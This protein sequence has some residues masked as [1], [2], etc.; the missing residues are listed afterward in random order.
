[1][2]KQNNKCPKCGKNTFFETTR[3]KKDGSE[4]SYNRCQSCMYH[5]YDMTKG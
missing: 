1:M 3:I 4:E 2:K 5:D